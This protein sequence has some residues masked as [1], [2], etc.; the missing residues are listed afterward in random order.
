MKCTC[1]NGIFTNIFTIVD[2]NTCVFN[3]VRTTCTVRVIRTRVV[4]TII[5][6]YSR[7]KEIGITF[8]FFSSQ[9]LRKNGF[10]LL[11]KKRENLCRNRKRYNSKRIEILCRISIR[12]HRFLGKNTSV[13]V[14]FYSDAF[15]DFSAYMYGIDE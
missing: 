13:V 12:K 4:I 2:S 11:G 9:N 8:C 5:I 15:V 10:F 14:L 1:V 6:Y 3:S 7:A